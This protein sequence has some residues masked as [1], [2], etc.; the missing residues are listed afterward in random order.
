MYSAIVASTNTGLAQINC[1]DNRTSGWDA[2]QARNIMVFDL[3]A[4]FGT[5][6]AD[7]VYSLET[8][9]AGSGVAWL[10]EHFPK[11]FDSGYIAHNPGEMVCVSGLSAKKTVGFNQWDEVAEAGT[12]S[13]TGA[14]V[15]SSS[16][17]RSKNYIPVIPS[18]KYYG[19]ASSSL[20]VYYYDVSIY[21]FNVDSRPITK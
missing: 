11:I 21:K 1:Q 15:L 18:A 20:L 10:K 19:N 4:A 7:Y 17:I 6:I 16:N 9:T 2:N 12:Y 13:N 3:T 5:A 14:P 8:A